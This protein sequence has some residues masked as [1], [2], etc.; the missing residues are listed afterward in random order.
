MKTIDDELRKYREVTETQ[1]REQIRDL[2]KITGWAFYFTFNSMHS[3][4]GMPDLILS[5]TLADENTVILFPELKREQGKLSP[6]QIMWLELLDKTQGVFCFVWTPSQIEMICETLR[7][8]DLPD[9]ITA[10]EIQ[11][12]YARNRF[13]INLGMQEKGVTLC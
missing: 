3:P 1:L 2:C 8:K 10:W 5:K 7:S 4:K 13:R 11:A 9:L 6:P 12:V